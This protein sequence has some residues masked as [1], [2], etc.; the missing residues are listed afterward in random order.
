MSFLIQTF[1][2]LFVVIDPVGLMPIFITLTGKHS[3]EQQEQIARQAVLVAAG[4][5]LVFALSGNW[6]LRY[7]G[8][9]IEAFEVAAGILLLKIALDMVFTKVEGETVEEEKEAQLSE[10]VSVFPLAIPLLA[11]PG[12]LASI[13]IFTSE[14][15]HSDLLS[16]V[17]IL[18]IAAVVLSITYVLFRFS[19]KLA[20]LLGYTGVL[21]V[22]RVL[23]VLLAALA[24]QYI[25]NGVIVVL[26]N[27]LGS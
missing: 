19:K 7:L 12:T 5:M 6:L 15:A 25:I 16:L 27:A 8:I 14:E 13:L 21:V 18:A 22:T 2:T 9:S 20:D 3:E 10:D 11:G 24:V 23:G 1:L 26:K 4:I 17:M